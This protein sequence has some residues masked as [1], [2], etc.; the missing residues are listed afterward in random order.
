MTRQAPTLALRDFERAIELDPTSSDPYAGRGE[1]RAHLGNHRG[2]VADAETALRLGTPGERLCY[3]AARI[4]ARAALAVTA[5]VRRK[6]RDVVILAHKYQDRAVDLLT[7][8]M[9][10]VPPER[11]AEFW[12]NQIQADPLLQPIIPRLRSWPSDPLREESTR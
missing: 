4:Y 5:E 10:R 2:A 7:E 12:R 8:A 11:R 6:G 1:A 3:N 9:R